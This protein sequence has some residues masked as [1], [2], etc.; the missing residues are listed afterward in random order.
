MP[1]DIYNLTLANIKAVF[2]CK[3]IILDGQQARTGLP[4]IDEGFFI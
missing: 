2:E 3:E 4:V 1:S